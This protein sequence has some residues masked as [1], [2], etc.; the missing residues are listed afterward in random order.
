[1]EL[2]LKQ[3]SVAVR[4]IETVPMDVDFRSKSSLGPIPKWSVPPDLKEPHSR[5]TVASGEKSSGA[6]KVLVN[7]R[8]PKDLSGEKR[9]L[10][11]S[12]VLR[13]TKARVARRKRGVFIV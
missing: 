9:E 6:W 2:V 12:A 3:I 4:W 11:L 8:I 13:P 7:D 1:M 10:T 5:G